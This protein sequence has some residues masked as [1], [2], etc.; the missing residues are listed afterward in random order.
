MQKLFIFSFV[1]VLLAT[2]TA[3]VRAEQALVPQSGSGQVLCY[4]AAG[5]EITCTGTGQDGEQQLGIAW[6]DP[7][8]TDN[9]NGT[10]TDNLTGLVW[11]RSANCFIYLQQWSNALSAAN[12]LASGA[13]GLTDGSVAGDWRLPNKKELESLVN[14]RQANPALWLNSVGFSGVNAGTNLDYYEQYYW[15]ST[16]YAANTGVAHAVHFGTGV[17][18]SLGKTYWGPAVWPVR[19]GQ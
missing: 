13:C 18:S 1:L 14:W 2:F 7:R 15:T 19:G 10:I 17:V 11:L 4:D 16:T 6:P 8:F 9:G 5:A 3:P 12:T